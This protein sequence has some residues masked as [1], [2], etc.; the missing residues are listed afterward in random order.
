MKL[1]LEAKNDADALLD[2]QCHAITAIN[3]YTLDLTGSTLSLKYIEQIGSALEKRKL[4]LRL[5]LAGCKTTSAAAEK[6]LW[7]ILI[8]PT[9]KL[10]MIDF[11]DSQFALDSKYALAVLSKVNAVTLNKQGKT[12]DNLANL[13]GDLENKASQYQRL[14]SILTPDATYELHPMTFKATNTLFAKRTEEKKEATPD[15]QKMKMA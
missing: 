9:V 14:G 2:K 3:D 6:K 10:L 5:V 11:T 15:S 12:P 13:F 7:E 8:K 1:L 4:P